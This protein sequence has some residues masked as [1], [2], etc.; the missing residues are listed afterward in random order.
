MHGQRQ[1]PPIDLRASLD[2]V[3]RGGLPLRAEERLAAERG[4]HRRLFTSDLSVSEF[5]LARDVNCHP[6]SQVMGSCIYHVGQIPD[7][8][9]KTS[10]ISVISDGHR[11]SR[12]AA[13]SRLYQ[14]AQ[15]VGADAVIGVHLRDRM[16]TMGARGKGGDDGGEI[17]E[18]TVV[19][20]AVRA[21]WIT[22]APN[23]PII[24]DLSG[25]EL[26]AL[27]QDGFEP[28]GFLFEFCRYHVWHVTKNV[29]A[30]ASSMELTEASDAVEQA[31]SIAAQRLLAQADAYL[32]EF[33]VGSDITVDVREVPCGYGGCVLDDLD[34]DVSW[35]GTGIRRI[36]GRQ[37]ERA[38]QVP[39]LILSMMP[40]GR[41][42][43]ALIE[44]ED[45]ANDI[46]IAAEEAQE[47][48]LEADEAASDD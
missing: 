19:G 8:K 12:R 27:A 17:L 4:D 39:P 22:H 47:A 43:D 48:A 1:R 46:E 38:H 32:A 26:W 21:P 34:V 25:Q 20:T 33:V 14:E 11:E 3:A 30:G 5:L 28:C 6:I 41:R 9:G 45:D 13:L 36:P 40:L 37:A 31:R 42:R 23:T 2:R 35:F 44:A 24:T 18:F 16:I 29:Q 15:L 7:Y 10:E